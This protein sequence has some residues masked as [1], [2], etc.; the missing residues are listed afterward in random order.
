MGKM[1]HWELCKKFK[2]DHVDKWFLH[3]L[4]TILEKGIYKLLWDLQTDRMISARRPD[5]I[6]INKKKK[7][8]TC[9]I[10]DFAIPADHRAKLKE[11]EKKD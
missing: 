10:V 8:R 9:R 1:I 4:A 5:I 2:F 11:S 3:N 7:K 6:I